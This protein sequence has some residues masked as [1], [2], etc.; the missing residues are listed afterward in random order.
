MKKRE[1][2]KHKRQEAERQKAQ[3]T[4]RIPE[5]GDKGGEGGGKGVGK[6]RNPNPQRRPL[7]PAI[8]LSPADVYPKKRPQGDNS[9]P[10]GST[11]KKRQLAWMAKSLRAAEPDVK[12]PAED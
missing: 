6:G 2:D 5:N 3:T 1:S 12:F 7:A 4:S 11:S 8:S 10:E 9:S